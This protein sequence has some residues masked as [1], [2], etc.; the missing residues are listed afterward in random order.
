MIIIMIVVVVIMIIIIIITVVVASGNCTQLL[1]RLRS[2]GTWVSGVS[3]G[4]RLSLRAS[5]YPLHLS[6]IMCL[7]FLVSV[8]T[9][10]LIVGLFTYPLHHSR[11]E[12][13]RII[14]RCLGIRCG[15]ASWPAEVIS[16]IIYV[17]CYIFNNVRSSSSISV[18]THG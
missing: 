12:R 15:Y 5:T 18:Q 13:A 3:G 4:A 11:H 6:L 1:H 16:Y 8:F 9:V 2:V 17:K 10:C 14:H 7:C